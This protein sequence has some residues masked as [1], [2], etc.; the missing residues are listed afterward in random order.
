VVQWLRANIGAYDGDPEAVFLMGQ[1][2]G[3]THV[4]AYVSD[5]RFHLDGSIGIAA[6]VMISGVY[7]SGTQPPN[8]FSSA[9]YGDDPATRAEARHTAGLL[10]AAVPLLFTVSGFD[11]RDF[12]AQATQLT[13]AWHAQKGV[14]PPLEYLAGHNH[15]SPAQAIGSVEDDL[16]PRIAQFIAAR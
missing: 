6:A 15:L 10:A 14:Y 5:A 7:D 16:G 11:A 3:A 4:A 9:Y 13:Q 1:S 8:Q 2:A 12:Q